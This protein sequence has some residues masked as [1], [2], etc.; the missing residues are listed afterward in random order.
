MKYSNWH[1]SAVRVVRSPHEHVLSIDSHSTIYV[2]RKWLIKVTPW[3]FLVSEQDPRKTK[4][5][6]L[7]N[8]LRWKCTLRPVCRRTSDWHS[9]V[10]LLE[11]L[12]ACTRAVFTFCFILESYKTKRVRLEHFCESVVL[13]TALLATEGST[14]NKIPNI[15]QCTLPLHPVHQTLLFDFSRVWFRDYRITWI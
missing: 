7:V 14:I 2:L 4:K 9:D 3:E 12:T 13:Q 10:H 15:P 5:E 11:M 1:A 8:R 6:G